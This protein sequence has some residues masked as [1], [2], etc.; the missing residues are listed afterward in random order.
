MELIKLGKLCVMMICLVFTSHAHSSELTYKCICGTRHLCH[1]I[2]KP[3][4]HSKRQKE[5]DETEEHFVVDVAVVV[6]YHFYKFY[7]FV[8]GTS[9]S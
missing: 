5:I 2:C 3:I 8:N 9:G 1:T 7:F 6:D 4:S